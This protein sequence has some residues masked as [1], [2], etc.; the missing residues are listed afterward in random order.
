MVW[1]EQSSRTV[2]NLRMQELGLLIFISIICLIAWISAICEWNTYSRI[3]N[4]VNAKCSFKCPNY[5]AAREKTF[6][7]CL[8]SQLLVFCL[9]VA[10][11]EYQGF[12][13][14]QQLK[15]ISMLMLIKLKW[16]VTGL[17]LMIALISIPNNRDESITE[18]N[19]FA[20]FIH[21]RYLGHK[22]VIQFGVEYFYYYI[23]WIFGWP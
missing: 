3:H 22:R 7:N 6:G 20:G 10:I 2:P 4:K 17:I 15:L 16:N 18:I 9:P 21:K 11:V 13:V 19:Y 12:L 8:S 23:V 5:N 1:M 14:Q